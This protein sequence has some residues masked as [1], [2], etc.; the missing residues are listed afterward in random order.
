MESYRLKNIILI[1]LALLNVFLISVLW[2]RRVDQQERKEEAKAQMVQLLASHDIGLEADL[3]PAGRPNSVLTLTRD[4]KEEE[5][6]AQHLLGGDTVYSYEGGSLSRY[7]NERGVLV[8]RSGGDF[9][10]TGAIPAE[11]PEALCEKFSRAFRYEESASTLENGSGTVTALQYFDGS[12]VVNATVVFTFTD[13]ELCSISGRHLPPRHSDE[14]QA[15]CI[16]AST[17]LV[18][19]LQACEE[20]GVSCDSVS[21]ITMGYE[22]QSTPAMPLSLLPVWRIRTDTFDCYV[23]AI[24]NEAVLRG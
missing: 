21:E 3:I 16:S 9:D 24:S 17:A 11:N 12:P 8:F 19:F 5:K 1:I 14:I 20:Q 18:T 7:E 4:V 22:L 10:L 23:N 2:I 6:L 15:E 13:Y